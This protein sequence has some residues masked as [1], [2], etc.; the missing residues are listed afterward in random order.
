MNLREILAPQFKE[1][2]CPREGMVEID[3]RLRAH[4]WLESVGVRMGEG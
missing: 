1:C 2:D 3:C 4:G